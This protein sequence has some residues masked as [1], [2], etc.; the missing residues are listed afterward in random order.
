MIGG[1]VDVELARHQWED[2]R[3][4]LE[5]ARA[6]RSAHD[7]LTDQVDIVTAELN[8]RVGQIFTL[9]DLA[10]VYESADR[11][12]IEVI[13]EARPNEV[14]AQASTAADAAFQRF[15][16]RASDYTP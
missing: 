10:S 14:P 3:R 12:V 13:H 15:S 9:E 7:R 11:W 6:D 4:A 1:I 16:H 5:R 2:G 8:R